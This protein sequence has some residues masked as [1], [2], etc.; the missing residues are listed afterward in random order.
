MVESAWAED[1]GHFLYHLDPDARKITR[2][3][4][5]IYIYIY[6]KWE[7]HTQIFL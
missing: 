3:L 4:E 2:S 5:Y 1:M 7:R 6:M